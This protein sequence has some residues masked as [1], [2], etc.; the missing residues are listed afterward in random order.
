[1]R[2]QL[3]EAYG[4]TFGDAEWQTIEALDAIAEHLADACC[5]S[6]NRK[7]SKIDRTLIRYNE[8]WTLE[9]LIAKLEARV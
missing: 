9:R 1:M 6:I 4:H 7:A 5:R 2:P 3:E 8:Q